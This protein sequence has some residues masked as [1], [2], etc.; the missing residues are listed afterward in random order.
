MGN[1]A[2]KFR[3][4]FLQNSLKEL[5]DTIQELSISELILLW[6]DFNEGE[7]LQ[8]FSYLDLEQKIDL[9]N[10]ISEEEQS[11]LLKALSSEGQ[12]QILMQMDPDDLAD[13]IQTVNHDVRETV[14]NSL[15]EETRK[16][17]QFLLRFDS[18]DAAGLMT[19]RYVAL[20]SNITVEQAIRFI[21]EGNKD[22]ET[23][24]Y[25]Y[26]VDNLQRLM[27]V[28]SLREILI[29]KDQ[30]RIGERM[31]KNV[32]SVREDTDQ[33][34]VAKILE[35]NDFIA[36]PVVD[37]FHRLLGIVT[38]DDVIDVIREEQTEDIYKMGAM[39]GSADVYLH[40]SVWKLLKKRIPWL[41]LLLLTGTITTN[42]LDLF[43]HI[44]DAAAFLIIFIP[45]ITQTGGNTGTQSSTLII[46]GLAMGEL[47][48]SDLGKVILKEIALGI[49]MGI[50]LGVLIL[51]RSL[52]LPPVVGLYEAVV[53]GFSLIFV[54]LFSTIIGSIA[55][56]LIHKA[57]G[58]P[59]VIAA[60][61]MST[62]IDVMGLTIYAVTA[63]T[64]L[65]MASG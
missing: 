63:Q 4:Y 26:V 17:T 19:P 3:E 1:L 57:G 6:H 62:F 25:V 23:I 13:L 14:W 51:A 28:I 54:V 20:R 21:R 43:S 60:P 50:I 35:D 10:Q 18:D 55:P 16:E 64:M 34:E 40:T 30:E 31:E 2:D 11:D 7:S 33:E 49:L 8:L 59:T 52:F 58:D 65:S 12:R 42:V 47:Q 27:G 46:R 22:L 32:I 9:I 24:Y 53:L 38:F 48:F 15:D 5:H 41:I 39:E 37:S 29:A 61:L 44:F 56:L 36:V 45:V